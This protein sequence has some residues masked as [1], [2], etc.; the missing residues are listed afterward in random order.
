ME[1][2]ATDN[3]DWDLCPDLTMAIAGCITEEHS[4]FFD[5]SDV[6]ALA[7][8]MAMVGH[9]TFTMIAEHLYAFISK[10]LGERLNINE[11]STAVSMKALLKVGANELFRTPCPHVAGITRNPKVVG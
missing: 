10:H 6:A 1:V 8:S 3:V 4:P 11:R 9:P 7:S 2:A 5:D